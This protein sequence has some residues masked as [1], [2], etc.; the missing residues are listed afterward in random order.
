MITQ[1]Q[2][3]K[4]ELE[5]NLT[6]KNANFVALAE[7]VHDYVGKYHFETILDFGC[8]T[9]VYSEV[10]RSNGVNVLAMDIFK[11]HRDYC[12][13]NYP[14]LKVIARPKEA[15]LMYFIEVAEHMTDEEIKTAISDVNP[16]L[17]LF[18]STPYSNE[19][20]KDWGH[21]NIK[22]ESEWVFQFERMGY[23]LIDKPQT[24][25]LWALMFKKI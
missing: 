19:Y 25:T 24:P 16:N 10:A 14:L 6:M 15:D 23:T 17:I 3:L 21:I 12:K 5:M 11:I 13:A 2:F 7:Q 18:S 1:E 20:D 22:Q 9:G 8:G 4:K